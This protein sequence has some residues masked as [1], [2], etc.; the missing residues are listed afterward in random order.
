MVMKILDN[1][2]EFIKNNLYNNTYVFNFILFFASMF[3]IEMIVRLINGYDLTSYAV[4]RIAVLLIIFSYI[5]CY[6]LNYFKSNTRKIVTSILVF[7]GST[8][9]CLQL[10]FLKFLGVYASLQSANQ[11]GAVTAY[12]KD[13]LKSF[14]Q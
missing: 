13:F 4:I 10:G 12:I 8:Y 5:I 6:I 7:I 11:A 3:S 9:A 2:K 1:F 14:K